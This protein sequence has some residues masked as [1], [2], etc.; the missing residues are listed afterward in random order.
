[1]RFMI[2]QPMGGHSEED[3]L[4]KKN[5]VTDLLLSQGHSVVD[6]YYQ[7]ELPST[8]RSEGLFWLGVSLM[9]MAKCDAVYFCRG[10]EQARGCVIEHEAALAYNTQVMYEK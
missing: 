10:W 4:L 9:D 8:I 1:M 5:E 6:T 2:S 3:I 7:R